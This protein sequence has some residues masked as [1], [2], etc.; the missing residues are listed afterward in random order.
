MRTLIAALFVSA[1]ISPALAKHMDFHHYSS[2]Q[3]GFQNL[4]CRIII[5]HDWVET[6][7]CNLCFDDRVMG[8]KQK[9]DP[10]CKGTK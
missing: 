2:D 6:W 7:H 9:P 3:K 1:F 10:W 5:H 8:Y 4:N